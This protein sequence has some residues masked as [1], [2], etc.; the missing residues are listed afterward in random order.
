MSIKEDESFQ[1]QDWLGVP[2]YSLRKVETMDDPEAPEEKKDIKMILDAML[3]EMTTAADVPTLPQ[4]FKIKPEDVPDEETTRKTGVS[5]TGPG[6][7]EAV[8]PRRLSLTHRASV[9]ESVEQI[10]DRLTEDALE[11]QGASAAMALYNRLTRLTT[12]VN[13][14]L[15]NSAELGKKLKTNPEVAL[16]NDFLKEVDAAWYGV[17]K[18]VAGIHQVK[19]IDHPEPSQRPTHQTPPQGMRQ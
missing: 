1:P 7:F 8:K 3:G 19:V 2:N 9:R 12:E 15:I 18:I 5:L 17:A 6:K 14:L 16:P 4:G 10:A 13:L 11:E